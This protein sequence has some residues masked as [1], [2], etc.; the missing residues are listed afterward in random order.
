M[1]DLMN[2][3]RAQDTNMVK[4]GICEWI[5]VDPKKDVINPPIVGTKKDGRGWYHNETAKALTPLSHL[6][7]F[8]EDPM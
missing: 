8:Q 5:P 3:A 6:A 1:V 2:D 7:E 4:Y